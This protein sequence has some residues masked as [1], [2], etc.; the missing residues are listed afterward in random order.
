LT[1][2][3]GVTEK[4][5]IYPKTSQ[6]AKNGRGKRSG[7]DIQGRMWMG[8]AEWNITAGNS[9][10]HQGMKEM[11]KS[12]RLFGIESRRKKAS[13]QNDWRNKERK[14]AIRAKTGGAGS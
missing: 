14:P 4:R 12:A 10:A 9:P 11:G 13:R 8:G 5:S 2:K 7:L 3:T 6:R 1:Q